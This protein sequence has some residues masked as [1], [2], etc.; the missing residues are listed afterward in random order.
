M[1]YVLVHGTENFLKC[2][3]N[4]TIIS[5]LLISEYIILFS[6]LLNWIVFN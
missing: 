2:L 3:I 5:L 4:I 1:K 6:I